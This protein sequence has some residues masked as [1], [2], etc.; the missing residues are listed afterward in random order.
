MTRPNLLPEA[1][2]VTVRY[3]RRGDAPVLQGVDY[4]GPEYEGVYHILSLCRSHNMDTCGARA[5]RHF[6]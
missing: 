1:D 5:T 3:A 6:Y 4:A 2:W